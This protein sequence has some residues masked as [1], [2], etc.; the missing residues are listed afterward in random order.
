MKYETENS[1]NN[2]SEVF[3][4]GEELRIGYDEEMKMSTWGRVGRRRH[5]LL[6]IHEYLGLKRSS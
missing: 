3:M 4:T 1:K 6:G 5:G 2:I